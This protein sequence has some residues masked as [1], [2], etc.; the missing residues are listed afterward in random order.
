MKHLCIAVPAALLIVG[1]LSNVMIAQ[2]TG[3][4]AV[5]LYALA[6]TFERPVSVDSTVPR[7]SPKL[8]DAPVAWDTAVFALGLPVE[9]STKIGASIGLSGEVRVLR[10]VSLE[11]AVLSTLLPRTPADNSNDK[12]AGLFHFP[13]KGRIKFYPHSSINIFTGS[14]YVRLNHTSDTGHGRGPSYDYFAIGAWEF[15]L[16]Y[17]FPKV[18]GVEAGWRFT[19]KPWLRN[20]DYSLTNPASPTHTDEKLRELYITA[21]FNLGLF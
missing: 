9:T 3:I 8:P 20:F 1:A 2:D 15:F 16:G 5:R 10:F 13:L 19:S 11:V 17:R 7:S 12:K 4:E 14:G 21:T 6:G 18:A